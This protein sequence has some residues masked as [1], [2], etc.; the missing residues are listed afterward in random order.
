[1]HLTFAE[2]Y[3]KVCPDGRTVAP[4]SKDYSDIMELMRQS[5]YVH[6]QDKLVKESV[7]K[8]PKNVLEAKQY[9]ERVIDYTA[10]TQLS[11]KQWL[12]IAVNKEMFL[13]HLTL[14]S[15]K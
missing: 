14:N 3:T 12:S 6:F 10:P 13:K 7:P 5:G 1:M 9:I 8:M 15:K 11:K 2:A 4:D